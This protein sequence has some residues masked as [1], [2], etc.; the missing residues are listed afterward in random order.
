MKKSLILSLIFP[1]ITALL[2][3]AF[4]ILMFSA[5]MSFVG[6]FTGWWIT[7]AAGILLGGALPIVLTVINKTDTSGALKIRGIIFAATAA[8]YVAAHFIIA[9]INEVSDTAIAVIVIVPIIMSAVYHIRR[10][11]KHLQ[12]I[13]ICLS[14]PILYFDMWYICLLLMINGVYIR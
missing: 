5:D 10:A 9:I 4:A 13:I 7:C 3:L 8:F 14:D 2:C 6:L 11:D 1:V 12:W